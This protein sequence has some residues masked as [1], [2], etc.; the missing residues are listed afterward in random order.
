VAGPERYAETRYLG[1]DRPARQY[2]LNPPLS[3]G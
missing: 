2:D 3:E 1:A